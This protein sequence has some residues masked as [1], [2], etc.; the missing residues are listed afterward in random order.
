MTR[1]F[2]PGARLDACHLD[3]GLP[4]TARVQHS[5]GEEFY[6][7][8]PT[9]SLFRTDRKGI[10]SGGCN[11]P[12]T[13]TAKVVRWWISPTRQPS[14]RAEGTDSQAVFRGQERRLNRTGPVHPVSSLTPDRWWGLS[15]VPDAD[16]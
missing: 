2:P 6:G 3:R 9:Q 11:P 12:I 5:S 4:C 13:Q 16:M 14:G 10:S 7:T 1:L 15:G 8:S